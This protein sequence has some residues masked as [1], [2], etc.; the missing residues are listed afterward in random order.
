MKIV[1]VVVDVHLHIH[2]LFVSFINRDIISKYHGFL[3][4]DAK[5]VLPILHLLFERLG[6]VEEEVFKQRNESGQK[7]RNRYATRQSSPPVWF[8]KVF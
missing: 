4:E 2:T 1:I 7:R 5:P 6:Q 3:I 8:V